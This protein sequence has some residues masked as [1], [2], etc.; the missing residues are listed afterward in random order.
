MS[1][2]I[3][4]TISTIIFINLACKKDKMDPNPPMFDDTPYVLSFGNLPQ[5]DLPQDNALTNEKVQLGRMLFY[6]TMMSKDGSMSCA[7][8]HKQ[9]EGF[10]DSTKFSI[11]VEGLPGKRQA[12]PIFNLAWHTNE[13]FWDG[14]AHLLRDQSLMPIQD[15][16]EMNETLENVIQKLSASQMYKDQ[17]IRAFGTDEINEEKMS[18][19]MEQFMLSITSYQSKYDKYL[20]G[21][22]NLLQASNAVWIFLKLSSIHFSLTSQVQIVL[23]AMVELILKMINI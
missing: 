3:Y 16:L 8:C 9:P 6:E 7:S 13:F 18:L 19:A 4:L 23:I 22:V 14:R 12:M 10:S 21:E 1:K 5:P 20:A 15:P 11:G 2:Y 17:F